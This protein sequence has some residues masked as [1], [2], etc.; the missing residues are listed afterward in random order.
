[1]FKDLSIILED[2]SF[3]V[4]LLKDEYYIEN[5]NFKS[6]EERKNKLLEDENLRMI[7][8]TDELEIVD[9]GNCDI[10][11]TGQQGAGSGY[12]SGNGDMADGFVDNIFG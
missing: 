1:M 7:K 2:K 12:G 11:T 10:I 4:N 9:F 5:M 8:K 3:I 6:I